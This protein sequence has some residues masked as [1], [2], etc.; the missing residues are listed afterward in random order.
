[1]QKT[2]QTPINKGTPATIHLENG[3]YL[4]DYVSSLPY[5]MIDKQYPGI[6]ATTLELEN[7]NRNSII[8]FPTRALA[9]TK[10]IGKIIHYV[11]SYYPY[12]TTSTTV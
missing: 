1:M 7:S 10:A 12:V 5:G 8:V 3:K 4:S 6:G 2:S 11:G 9:A